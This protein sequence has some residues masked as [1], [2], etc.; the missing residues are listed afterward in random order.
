MVP[1]LTTP[2]VNLFI[3]NDVALCKTIEAG[4][5]VQELMLRHRVR[6]A[7]IVGPS[8]LQVQWQAEML[9]KFGL[10]FRIIDS[11]RI[12]QLRRK[13]GIHGN[14]WR[15]FP[16]LIT[17]IDYGRRAWNML[18]VDDAH[19]IASSGHG[20]YALDSQRTSAPH[21][22]HSLFLAATPHNSYR[23]GFASLLELVEYQRFAHAVIP[24]R[25]QLEAFM[26]RRMKSELN[27][28]SEADDRP[29]SYH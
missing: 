1:A 29:I 2:C 5:L 18:I 23:E 8:S 10:E 3:A 6:S 11:N 9:D 13:R 28:P 26:A 16:R 14:P 22:E 20:K 7:L 19:N 17:S 27:L 12:S 4:L 15:H 25:A 21:F 24:D